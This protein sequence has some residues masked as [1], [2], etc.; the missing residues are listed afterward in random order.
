MCY[1]PWEHGIYGYASLY[2]EAVHE[3]KREDRTEKHR[4]AW[5]G[6]AES[7]A[8]GYPDKLAE[9]DDEDLEEWL[10]DIESDF[11]KDYQPFLLEPAER[12]QKNRAEN[13]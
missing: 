3:S 11:S 7:F 8:K 2:L 4:H 6:K 5:A 9:L 13:A 12:E 1:D 10:N